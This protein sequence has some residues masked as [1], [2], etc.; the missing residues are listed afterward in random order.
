[1]NTD[2]EHLKLL[3][4]FHFV[5]AGMAFLFAC[6]PI[7]HFFVG[8]ALVSG[9]FPDT[10]GDPNAR[11]FGTIVMIVA[12]G[13]VLAGWSFATAIAMA[14]RSLALRRHY[15]FCLVMAGVS[16]LFVPFGTVLGVFTIIVLVRP[17]VS[18]LFGVENRQ[19]PQPASDPDQ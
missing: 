15:T 13:I 6:I 5:V 14:G 17:S 1:M 10:G 2:L 3:S 8:L 16:C 11:F 9:W 18:A 19:L 7:I 12:G 4:I